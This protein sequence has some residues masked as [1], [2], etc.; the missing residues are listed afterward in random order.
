MNR[1]TLLHLGLAS[2][3]VLAIAGGGV[4]LIRPGLD[5]ARLSA[6]GR[7]IFRAVARAVLDDLLPSE[8]A[9]R[10]ATL[11]A[12]LG[13]LD[14]TIAGLPAS[15]RAELSRLLALL[16]SGA[17]RLALAGLAQRWEHAQGKSLQEALQ[18]MRTS[19]IQ[20]RQ[21]A[22]HA[23]RDLTNAAY[24]ADSRTWPLIGYPGPRSS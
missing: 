10:E 16:D 18:S 22:Y 15:S 14:S 11:D 8:S 6:G 3:A 9:L 21:Q 20:L 12:H 2:A 5:G 23:L 7:L 19:S 13:R 24:F 17:G 4:A 1:R